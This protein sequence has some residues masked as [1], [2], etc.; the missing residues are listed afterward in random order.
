[1]DTVLSGVLADRFGLA[2]AIA[3][4]GI[5]TAVSGVIV[6]VRMPEVRGEQAI[7]PSVW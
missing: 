3:A 1:V 4:A 2:P 7:A 5:L 6:A